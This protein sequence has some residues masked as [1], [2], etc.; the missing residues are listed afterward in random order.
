MGVEAD[1]NTH[2]SKITGKSWMLE[3][4]LSWPMNLFLTNTDIRNYNNVFWFLLFLRKTRLRLQS[5][6]SLPRTQLLDHPIGYIIRTK[7]LFFVNC[8]ESYIYMDLIDSIPLKSLFS[9]DKTVTLDQIKQVHGN[10][11]EKLI[12]GC[13]LEPGSIVGDI[14]CQILDGCE[15]ICG[16]LER[17]IEYDNKYDSSLRNIDHHLESFDKV[18]RNEIIVKSYRNFKVIF[19]SCLK[20][21][22]LYLNPILFL[23][24]Y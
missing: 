18:N 13:F 21:F 16:V 4:E 10:L 20:S 11:L 19:E 9:C 6:W 22:Q 17:W 7:L 23:N 5:V 24:R 14:I 1:S 3:Y 2:A 12:K 15:R 8:L